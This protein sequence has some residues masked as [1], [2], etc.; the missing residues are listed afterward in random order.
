MGCDLLRIKVENIQSVDIDWTYFNSGGVC[1]QYY[2]FWYRI[3]DGLQDLRLNSPHELC[4]KSYHG[5]GV[6]SNSGEFC[7]GIRLGK[8]PVRR[9]SYTRTFIFIL[10]CPRNSRM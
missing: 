3:C 8:Y 7:V 10:E 9:L 6:P 5:K 2:G 4:R 1:N